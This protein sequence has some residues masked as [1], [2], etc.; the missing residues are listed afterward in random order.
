[1]PALAVVVMAVFMALSASASNGDLS[2]GHGANS[3]TKTTFATI[4]STAV[5]GSMEISG[6][7]VIRG[8]ALPIGTYILPPLGL[9]N[10]SSLTY[11]VF[12]DHSR[13][14]SRFKYYVDGTLRHTST[15]AMTFDFI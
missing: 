3:S 1:M 2:F 11:E 15:A 12:L 9:T 8:G 4:N 10:T 13:G 14:T 5:E 6:T 7:L